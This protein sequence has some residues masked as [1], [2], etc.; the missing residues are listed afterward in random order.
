MMDKEKLYQLAKDLLTGGE[1]FES[2]QVVHVPWREDNHPSGVILIYDDDILVYDRSRRKGVPVGVI[3]EMDDVVP[4]DYRASREKTRREQPMAVVE[5]A[6]TAQHT[7][8]WRDHGMELRTVAWAKERLRPV[9]AVVFADRVVSLRYPSFVV[10][11][12]Q[13]NPFKVY[14]FATERR[15]KHLMMPSPYKAVTLREGPEPVLVKSIKDAVA[16]SLIFPERGVVLKASE[17]TV[18]YTKDGY[19]QVDNDEPGMAIFKRIKEHLGGMARGLMPKK[20]KDF[21]DML[22]VWKPEQARQ[23]IIVLD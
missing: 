7:R 8:V 16:V 17:N 12:G 10:L 9:S 20:E 6:W 15:Y 21:S 13:G 23:H 2:G 14:S 3:K 1:D 22:K 4:G 19:H 5:A 18:L 11:D